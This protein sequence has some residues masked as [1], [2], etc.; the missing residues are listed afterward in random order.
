MF[1]I[2][3]YKGNASLTTLR[4]HLTLTR[5]AIVRGISGQVKGKGYRGVKRMELRF[6]CTH[7]DNVM[8]P[9][10]HCLKEGGRGRMKL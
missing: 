5:L 3:R 4:F 6:T 9:T 7:E 8:K 1:N 10:R 2:F